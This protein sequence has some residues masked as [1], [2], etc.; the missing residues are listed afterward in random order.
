MK[1]KSNIILKNMPAQILKIGKLINYL[2][3][4]GISG[5]IKFFEI[6]DDNIKELP[7]IDGVIQGEIPAKFSTV[8]V[9]IYHR[10]FVSNLYNIP[11]TKQIEYYDKEPLWEEIDSF[12]IDIRELFLFLKEIEFTG[13]IKIRDIINH[14]ISFVFLESGML[15]AAEKNSY[16]GRAILVD[17]LEELANHH[18]KISVYKTSHEHLSLYFSLYRHVYTTTDFNRVIDTIKNFDI[19]VVQVVKEDDV[20]LLFDIFIDSYQ[21]ENDKTIFYEIYNVYRLAT[22]IPK[23]DYGDI[24]DAY[25]LVKNLHKARNVRI[26]LS[27][28]VCC[29]TVSIFDTVCP[30]CGTTLIKSNI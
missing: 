28:P 1:K 20:E 16:K 21:P 13:F 7:F 3:I 14:S 4:L 23:S 2:P 30:V 26:R 17:I 12:L 6:D 29:S 8:S 25:T 22:H 9:D 24:K 5:V 18:C 27:C 11:L 10:R 15:I 19:S